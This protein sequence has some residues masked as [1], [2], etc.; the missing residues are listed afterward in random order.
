MKKPDPTLPT[1]TLIV[2][3]QPLTRWAIDFT[4]I[5]SVPIL[6]AVEYATG[7]VEAEI[8]PDQTFSSTIPLLIRIHN[9]FGAPREWISDN[10]GCFDGTEAKAWHVRHGSR[11]F[12]VT[13]LRPRGNGKVKKVN[14]LLKAPVLREWLEHPNR[15]I[16]VS[17]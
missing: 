13:P 17:L 10:A 15:D 7:W 2:P 12:P 6:V 5:D 1:L 8:T 11:V 4:S 3:P 14:H 9:T 16:K